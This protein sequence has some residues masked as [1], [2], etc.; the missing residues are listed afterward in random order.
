MTLERQIVNHLKRTLPQSTKE[1]LDPQ[2]LR[3]I[4]KVIEDI[5]KKRQKSNAT[6]P[7]LLDGSSLLEKIKS[8]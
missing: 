8:L 2:S 6:L 4:A 5:L 7:E 3:E 1:K